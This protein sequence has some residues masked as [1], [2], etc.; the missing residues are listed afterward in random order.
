MPEIARRRRL[1]HSFAVTTTLL[2]MLVIGATVAVVHNRVQSALNRGLSSR[3][4]AISSSIGAVAT[5]SLL[6]YNYPALQIA[7]ERAVE[8]PALLYVVI[9]D[10]EGEIAGVAGPTLAT[11]SIP[12]L[13]RV[14]REP[15]SRRITLVDGAGRTRPVLEA[16]VPVFVEG[17]DEPWGTVRVGLGFTS[18]HTELRRLEAGLALSG[19]VLM[20][21]AL[22]A[23]R[24]MARRITAPLRRLAEGTAALAGGDTSFRIPV[25]GARELA[26]LGHAFNT[27]MDRVQEKADESRAYENELAELNATLEQQVYERTRALEES[28][29]QYRTLVEHSPDSIL[30]IQGSRVCF[31]NPAFCTTFGLSENRALRADFRLDGIFDEPYREIV[32]ARITAWERGEPA[33]PAQVKS[34]DA[35]GNLRELELRGSRIEYRGQPAAECLLVDMTEAK[36]L[37][38]RLVDTERL[39]AL[40]ELSSGVA[41]DFNNLLGAILGRIQLLRARGFDEEI[42]RSMQVIEKAAMDGRETVR[43]IQEF[44]RVRTDRPFRTVDL[45]E[46]I[47]DA[48]EITR[49][50]WK[51]EAERRNVNIRVKVTS[52]AVPPILGNAHELREVY[53]NLILNAVDAMPDGGDLVLRCRTA[54]DK[55]RSEVE[56][57]GIGMSEVARR[58]LFDPFFTTKGHSGTGLGMSV[59][60]GIVTRHDGTIEVRSRPGE[61]T[62]FTLEFPVCDRPVDVAGGDGAVTPDLVRPGRILVIDDEQPVAQ[63]LEDALTGA[64][65]TVETA[66]SGREGVERASAAEFDLVLTDL[67]MPDMSGWEVASEIRAHRPHVPVILVTG[68]GATLSREEVERSGVSAVVHKPF[69]IQE[70]IETTGAVLARCRDDERPR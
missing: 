55:V 23:S 43:R 7:A 33:S 21:M 20:L 58:H 6:A 39:R 57:S 67:G 4:V 27:M 68:W 18:V 35:A 5:P 1:E 26:E 50:R 60:Y 25:S 37:R 2:V 45:P 40:G 62:S 52:E 53:T 63:V 69:E 22:A 61:G 31:V 59:A 41:H 49:T 10:K 19:F 29:A 9:H 14:F 51:N 36:R 38:E 3:A 32:D 11:A 46:I 17:V 12:V 8:D 24:F 47:R 66:G 15:T 30:I 16:V 34:R 13:G 48:V 28:E 54:G 42:D 44:S 65:H 70:L 64:G 56:D